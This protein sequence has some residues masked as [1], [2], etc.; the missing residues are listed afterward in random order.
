MV[1]ASSLSALPVQRLFGAD[2]LSQ[3]V[4]IT[5][6]ALLTI[7]RLLSVLATGPENLKSFLQILVLP[8]LFGWLVFSV[9]AL[10]VD[11][12][13]TETSLTRV[14]LVTMTYLATGLG[15][16]ILLI[17][18]PGPP[19]F[20]TMDPGARLVTALMTSLVMFPVVAGFV[21]DARRYSASVSR[22]SG[23]KAKLGAAIEWSG[24]SLA[25]SRL[26]LIGSVRSQL[27]TAFAPLINNKTSVSVRSAL[28]QMSELSRITES[29]VQPLSSELAQV[30]P[31]YEAS[32]SDI[33]PMRVTISSV[34]DIATRTNPFMPGLYIWASILLDAAMFVTAMNWTERF[35]ALSVLAALGLVHLVARQTITPHLRKFRLRWRLAVVG[36]VYNI[37]LLPI[38]V[39]IFVFLGGEVTAVWAAMFNFVL[40]WV[41][42]GI[43]AAKSGFGVARQNAISEFEIAAE[44]LEWKVARI[45]CQTWI[46]QRNLATFLHGEVQ[47]L[48]LVAQLRMQHAID[49][50]LDPTTVVSEVQ[51]LLA[52]IPARIGKPEIGPNLQMFSES[53]RDRWDTFVE[54]DFDFSNATRAAIDGD[55]VCVSV[56]REIVTEF[57]VNAVK[58]GSARRVGITLDADGDGVDVVLCSSNDATGDSESFGVSSLGGTATKNRPRGRVGLG[59][60]LLESVMVN[61]VVTVTEGD[62]RLTGTIPLERQQIPGHATSSSMI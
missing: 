41:F 6:L 61:R 54:F 19:V 35:W 3:P 29:V 43:S 48:I 31:R 5:V 50:N 53:L 1:R 21:A 38:S 13:A 42:L 22:V 17:N 32:E 49:R 59:S 58:H 18:A 11:R 57:V 27:E 24:K 56:I 52:G 15:R 51:E 60:D 34:L 25:E 8:T 10:I 28:G 37:S 30:A 16:E 7:N 45:N 62:Y 47:S 12:V 23:V 39:F 46:D 33:P 4:V 2:A 40:G 44:R 20:F 26:A 14:V 36:I 55:I 9:C